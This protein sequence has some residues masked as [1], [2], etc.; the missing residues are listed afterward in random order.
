MSVH[1]PLAISELN[2]AL[3]PVI[4][5]VLSILEGQ[6][7]NFK[8]GRTGCSF[9]WTERVRSSCWMQMV[10]RPRFVS[11][12]ESSLLISTSVFFQTLVLLGFVLEGYD[13]M[14]EA[15]CGEMRRRTAGH[16]CSLAP[17][18]VV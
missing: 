6:R 17:C 13:G 15:I 2:L 14:G 9:L 3:C 11:G 7:K 18:R 16:I 8:T 1:P 10:N 5:S 12:L 4:D